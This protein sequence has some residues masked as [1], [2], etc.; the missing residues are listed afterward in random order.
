MATSDEQLIQSLCNLE[1]PKTIRISGDRKRVLYSSELTWGHRKGKF[2][3]STLWLAST[4]IPDSSV[5]LTPGLFRDYSPAWSPDGNAVAFISDRAGAGT[6]W[7]LYLLPLQQGGEAYPITPVENASPIKGFAFSPSGSHIAFLSADEEDSLSTELHAW[8]ESWRYTRLRVVDVRTKHVRTLKLDRH[9]TGVC[10][11]PDGTRI[12][13]SSCLTPE[14]EEDYLTGTTISIVDTDLVSVE[15]LCHFPRVIVDLTWV[16]DGHLYF[17]AGVPATK[18]FA[19]C[20]VYRTDSSSR[21][22]LYEWAAFGIE[23]DSTGLACDSKGTLLVQV[24]HRLESRVCL[25]DGTVLYSKKEELEAFAAEADTN[26]NFVLAV[27]TSNVNQPAEVFTTYSS[28]EAPMTKLSN[29]GNI[30]AGHRFGTCSF[31]T[32]MSSDG[33]VE[34]DAL[35]LT[36]ASY[37]SNDTPSQPLPTVVLI[38]GGPNTRVTNAF[39][40]YYYMLAPYLLSLGFGIL[41]PNYRGSSGRGERFGSYSIGGL[42]I[43]DYADLITLTQCAIDKGFADKERLMVGGWSQ[44]GFLTNL[45]SVR[46]GSHNGGWR[47]RAAMPGASI[48]DIDSMALTSDLGSTFEPELSRDG[49][50]WNMDSNDTRNRSA[51]ALWGFKD[52]SRRTAAEGESV[53]PP[54]LILHGEADL[55]CHVTQAWGLRRALRSYGIPF[56]LVIYP[57]QGHFFED[58]KYW[59]DM[60]L[61]TGRWCEKYIGDRL[62]YDELSEDSEDEVCYKGIP[63]L[64][65]S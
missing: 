57:K 48:C 10:W 3:V 13:F 58:Q 41:L 46:N 19:G 16:I 14:I 26:G 31:L 23:N 45:C 25:L 9:V 8:G 42:G 56:E 54:M 39:N 6:K 12:G 11:S 24:Q 53:V 30:F 44:G 5:Q 55:R 22:H 2:A 15:E 21:D 28:G 29:H 50:A 52:A 1:I 60:A 64:P 36:P 65:S 62:R 63:T 40:T 59:V 37:T 49:V 35:Y 7:A 38:H 32:Q 61:R 20:G 17:C 47:F 33:E 43:Y 27:A 18:I 4:G 34:L 51:S